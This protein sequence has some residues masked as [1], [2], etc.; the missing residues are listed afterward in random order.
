MKLI[1]IV[2]AR[3]QFIKLAPLSYALR[4][5]FKNV[6]VHTGQHFDQEMSD[7]FFSEL[8]ICHPKYNLG[9]QAKS[10]GSQTGRM[11]AELEGVILN[12]QPELVIVF[13]DTNST[14]SGALAAAKLHIPVAHVEAGLRSYNRIMPEEINRILTDQLSTILFCPTEAA[15]ENLKSEGYPHQ[16]GKKNFQQIFNVGDI[17][18]DSHAMAVEKSK[19][20]TIL[21]DLNVKQGEYYL[22]TLHRPYNVDDNQNLSFMFTELEKLGKRIVFP[23]HPR[24]KKTIDQN[25]IPIPNNFI[26]L[27]PLGYLDFVHLQAHCHKIITDSGGIQKEAYILKKPCITLRSETEWLETVDAGW[28]LLINPFTETNYSEKIEAFEPPSTYK[29]IFGEN[30]AE[31]MV[32]IIKAFG[33]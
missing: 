29:N 28:N 17:M 27:K 18:V 30:V 33:N 20:K 21:N 7:S 15:V 16:I 9:I 1:F 22:L 12:E 19:D 23:I 13:G 3:P 14:L 5:D 8:D 26:C 25:S 6:I 4:K 32:K 2:G 10:H 24:T 11:L 31:K